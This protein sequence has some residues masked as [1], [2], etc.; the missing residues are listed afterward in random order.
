MITL[1]N[2]TKNGA[3]KQ[4]SI[5]YQIDHVVI[6]WGLK[7]GKM[8]TVKEYGK[9]KNVGKKNYIDKETDA[10]NIFDR[11]ILADDFSQYLNARKRRR[12]LA[13]EEYFSMWRKT[14]CVY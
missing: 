13:N 5:D 9:E 7:G 12:M 14:V 10:L 3:I 11:K 8:Q 2:K 1:Y 6:T 4:W